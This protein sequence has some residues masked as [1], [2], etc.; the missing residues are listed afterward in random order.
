MFKNLQKLYWFFFP[1]RIMRYHLFRVEKFIREASSLHNKANLKILDIGAESRPYEKYFDQAEYIAQDIQQNSTNTIDIIGDINEGLPKILDGSFDVI[2]CSQVLEHLKRPHVAFS[3]FFRILKPE[4][5]LYL[6][7]HLVF[8]EHM[9]PHDYFRF[10]RYGLR[11]LGESSGFSVERVSPHGGIFQVLA[12]IVSTLPIK[13]FLRQGSFFY[14]AYGI[15]FAIP[16]FI[17]NGLCSVLDKLDKNKTMTLNYECI[18]HKSEGLP[19][20]SS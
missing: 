14:F 4:G 1:L 19:T 3:E 15:V 17:F 2:I 9:I 8:E 6:T 20:G 7:T 16:I 18:Y 12:L 13:L 5:R 11:W 10:T